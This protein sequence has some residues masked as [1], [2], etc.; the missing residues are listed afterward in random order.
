MR[1]ISKEQLVALGPQKLAEL[2]LNVCHQQPEL[3]KVVLDYLSEPDP[4]TDVLAIHQQ[5]E[6]IYEDEHFISYHESE[7]FFEHLNDQFDQI[8]ELLPGMAQEAFELIDEFILRVPNLVQRIDDASGGLR[9]IGNNASLLWLDCASLLQDNGV[10]WVDCLFERAGGLPASVVEPLLVN[11]QRVLTI[12]QLE[13]LAWRYEK[14]LRKLASHERIVDNNDTITKAD[15]QEVRHRL[16]LVA[17]ALCDGRLFERSFLIGVDC[18]SE[19]D[20]VQIVEQYLSL[21]DP[22]K[23]VRWILK[24]N[25]NSQSLIQN[26]LGIQCHNIPD[27]HASEQEPSEISLLNEIDCCRLLDNAFSQLDDIEGQLRVRQQ[28]FELAP[29]VVNYQRLAEL[30]SDN[31]RSILQKVITESLQHIEDLPSAVLLLLELEEVDEAERLVLARGGEVNSSIHVSPIE[32]AERFAE[33]GCLLPQVVCYRAML[34]SLLANQ[35]SDLYLHGQGYLRLLTQLD[36]MV[37]SYA[38][39][40]SHKEYLSH[41]RQTMAFLFASNNVALN[42]SSSAN[43]ASIGESNN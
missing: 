21:E 3:E 23:A 8:C 40:E 4:Y 10:D 27:N 38:P 32:L 33:V 22:L 25:S 36:A 20:V 29:S 43:V 2:L 19:S 13:Q 7:Y 35:S 6:A 31:Q 42:Q 11:A 17:L 39:I 14:H 15:K 37:V 16:R 41:L 26:T 5:L 24:A 9:Q 28:W 12:E 34:E 18:L 1:S 30:F